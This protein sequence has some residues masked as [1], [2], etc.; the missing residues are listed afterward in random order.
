MHFLLNCLKPD[1]VLMLFV[2]LVAL[3]SYGYPGYR[4]REDQGVAWLLWLFLGILAAVAWVM[5][6]FAK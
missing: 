3:L 2:A 5:L 4:A 6:V 1:A